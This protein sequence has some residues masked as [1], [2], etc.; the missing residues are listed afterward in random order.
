MILRG[1]PVRFNLPSWCEPCANGRHRTAGQG[2]TTRTSQPLFD[3]DGLVAIAIARGDDGTGNRDAVVSTKYPKGVATLEAVN[4][5][6]RLPFDE[7]DI[8]QNQGK[9]STWFLLHSRTKDELEL[10]L[11]H[12]TLINDHGYITKW[13]VRL[14]L[15]PLS[16]NSGAYAR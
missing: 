2:T 6:L 13:D 8:A 1:S 3:P 10:E 15:K 12:P 14:I 4:Q 16:L 7:Q 9:A 11:S 5:N